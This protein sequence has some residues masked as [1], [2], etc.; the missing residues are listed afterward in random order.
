MSA[1]GMP[2]TNS[3][4]CP[5]TGSVD[6]AGVELTNIAW[7][8]ERVPGWPGK[9]RESL[10]QGGKGKRKERKNDMCILVLVI[11]E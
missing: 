4:P 2:G 11:P 7:S 8:I 3:K 6:Q 10:S 9:H 5:G 1:D